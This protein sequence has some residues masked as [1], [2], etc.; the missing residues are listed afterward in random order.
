MGLPWPGVGH[1]PFWAPGGTASGSHPGPNAGVVSSDAGKTPPAFPPPPEQTQSAGNQTAALAGATHGGPAGT[2]QGLCAGPEGHSSTEQG[3]AERSD[4]AGPTPEQL[5]ALMKELQQLA[6]LDPEAQKLLM[7]DLAKTDPALWKPLME[8]FRI[9]LEYH[10]RLQES[11]SSELGTA[12]EGSSGSE[13]EGSSGSE[14]TGGGESSSRDLPSQPSEATGSIGSGQKHSASSDGT[15]GIKD[16][17]SLPSSASPKAPPPTAQVSGHLQENARK[18]QSQRLPPLTPQGP[19]SSGPVPFFAD[20]PTTSVASGPTGSGETLSWKKPSEGVSV[21]SFQASVGPLPVAHENGGRPT[22]PSVKPSSDS[23]D[24]SGNADRATGQGSVGQGA[25]GSRASERPPGEDSTLSG[26]G[27][28]ANPPGQTLTPE[29]HQPGAND[30]ASWQ[31]RLTLLLRQMREGLSPTPQTD[32]EIARHIY[33]RLMCLAADR[34]EEALQPIP[35]VPPAM[36]DFWT[37]QLYAIHLLLDGR[38]VA[39]RG[40]RA[41]EAKRLFSEATAKLAVAAPLTVKGLAFATEVQSFGC[42]GGFEKYE[43]LP[44]QEVLLYAEVENFKSEPT[45]KGFHTK[46][47]SRYQ[48]FNSE[49]H[50]VTEQEFPITEEYC[51]QLRRDFFIAYPL[52]L[53]RDLQPGRYTL[54]LSLE[55]LHRGELSQASIELT[56]RKVK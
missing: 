39:D 21:A 42:Y 17:S 41:A 16:H 12:Y 13:K 34:R 19:L 1:L 11:K 14:K 45:A 27:N 36:Q 55:D 8:R 37:T 44:G 33:Y 56:I 7:E 47:R 20:P 6:L 5:H 46:L 54:K 40:E 24:S 32:E 4:S 9:A 49:G 15:G 3:D 25:V 43:F 29:S 51:R 18:Q 28:P 50:P 2:G 53:P 52:Q 35:G 31:E 48:I 10:R 26:S 30:S 23:G 38:Q 22:S